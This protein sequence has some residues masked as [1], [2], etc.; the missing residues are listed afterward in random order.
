MIFML[1]LKSLKTLYFNE[2]HIIKF[3]KYFKKQ[4]NEN[5]IIEKKTISQDLLLLC[6]IHCK[7]YKNLFFIY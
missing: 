2:Q 5:K 3:F 7:V 1:T 4:S 6:Q